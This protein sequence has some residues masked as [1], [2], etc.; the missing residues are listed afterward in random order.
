MPTY[1]P[2][3]VNR[4]DEPFSLQVPTLTPLFMSIDPV[5]HFIHSYRRLEQMPLEDGFAELACVAKSDLIEE[6]K[7]LR[8]HFRAHWYSKNRS[9]GQF[10]LNLPQYRQIHLL[11]QW[12]LTHYEDAT[13]LW[14]CERDSR[15]ALMAQAPPL[16]RQLHGLV[17]FFENHSI[18]RQ[19]AGRIELAT[20][21]V[22][23]DRRF[24]NSTNWGDY[25]LSLA[26]PG[27]LLRQLI[28]L[29]DQ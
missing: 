7:R 24:G 14:E 10:Y 8:K 22:D 11:H 6:E 15:F 20:L 2:V 19:V 27:D 9:F 5:I 29:P 13:Y 17:L 3:S 4:L 1:G 23:P 12:D 21:P 25:I 16:A 26:E 28:R 18:N